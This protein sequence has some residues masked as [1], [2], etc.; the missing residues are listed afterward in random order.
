MPEKLTCM[1]KKVFNFGCREHFMLQEKNNLEKHKL[2]SYL[3]EDIS[4]KKIQ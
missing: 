1:K 2:S 3:R 4:K